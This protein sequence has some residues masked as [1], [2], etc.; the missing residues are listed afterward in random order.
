MTGEETMPLLLSP[1]PLKPGSRADRFHMLKNLGEVVEGLLARQMATKRRK[2]IRETS[3][4][5]LNGRLRR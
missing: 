5:S 3:G 4:C 2:N 1:V